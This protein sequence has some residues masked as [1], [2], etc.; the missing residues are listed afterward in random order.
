MKVIK[1]GKLWSLRI[2]CTGSGN[3]LGGCGAI[4]E[5]TLPDLFNTYR[6]DYGNET[7]KYYTI[8]CMLCHT[9]TDIC[10]RQI[11]SSIREQVWLPERD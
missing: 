9:Q 11:P 6:H 7:T 10:E 1:Y 2:K 8:K 3:G 5:I 4:L